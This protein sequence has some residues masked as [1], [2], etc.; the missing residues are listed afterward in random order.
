[1]KS[2]SG[3]E[4]LDGLNLE[5]FIEEVLIYLPSLK[6]IDIQNVVNKVV[7]ISEQENFYKFI[8]GKGDYPEFF[9]MPDEIAIKSNIYSSFKKEK[10]EKLG[11]ARYELI[12][13][14]L[15][16][17]ENEIKDVYKEFY[18]FLMMLEHL[19]LKILFHMSSAKDMLD[20]FKVFT[21]NLDYMVVGCDEPDS[22]GGRVALR[23]VLLPSKYFNKETNTI[24]YNEDMFNIDN[25][26]LL[27]DFK[28]SGIYEDSG[29]CLEV[30]SILEEGK[31]LS[32]PAKIKFA[33]LSIMYICSIMHLSNGVVS[34][35][36]ECKEIYL[37]F[38]NKKEKI[39]SEC[40]ADKHKLNK[41]LIFKSED[42]ASQ[43]I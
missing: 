30:F 12:D 32:K 9:F 33:A 37:R 39:C 2:D 24:G 17:Y 13:I 25:L 31:D 35:C 26:G 8:D 4:L 23:S 16:Q 21:N 7:E 15:K 20:I 40:Y 42:K 19:F 27:I 18:L 41:L 5:S 22:R 3:I 29:L 38:N 1:M 6:K 36:N 34:I 28:D 14:A 10:T 43:S 11:V